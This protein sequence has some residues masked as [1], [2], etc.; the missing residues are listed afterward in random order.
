MFKVMFVLY[1]RSGVDRTGA[2]KQWR[3]IHT[4]PVRTIP[5]VTGYLQYHA[6]AAPDGTIPYLGVAGLAFADRNAFGAAAAGPEFA[7]TLAD[8]AS[9]A[10]ETKLPTAFV[11]NVIGAYVRSRPASP[12]RRAPRA[13]P[14]T[15]GE[16]R[17]RLPPARH[18]SRAG[19]LSP[20]NGPAIS[21][22]SRS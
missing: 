14:G 5:G 9:F 2:L 7:A 3:T 17:V 20:R 10:D 21:L 6:A 19:A 12:Q 4:D 15:P 13:E 11:E 18:L 22:R 1:E 16:S 8:A